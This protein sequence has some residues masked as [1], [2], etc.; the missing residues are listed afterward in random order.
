MLVGLHQ[1]K[2]ALYVIKH[3]NIFILSL[4]ISLICFL[5][6]E[7]GGDE[8]IPEPRRHSFTNTRLSD[9]CQALGWQQ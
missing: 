1:V 9:T 2:L 8:R 3:V 5:L 7:G 6:L 4:I